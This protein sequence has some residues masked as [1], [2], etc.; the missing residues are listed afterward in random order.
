MIII[1]FFVKYP[2]ELYREAHFRVNLK[3]YYTDKKMIKSI[4]EIYIEKRYTENLFLRLLV[5]EMV[6]TTFK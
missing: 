4:S 5:E 3:A 6:P 2:F 1:L